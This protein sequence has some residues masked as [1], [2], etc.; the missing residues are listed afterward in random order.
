MLPELPLSVEDTAQIFDVGLHLD[1][2][3][4]NLQGR[5]F[6]QPPSSPL[7]MEGLP[8]WGRDTLRPS[9]SLRCTYHQGGFHL[10]LRPHLLIA[11]APEGGE[12]VIWIADDPRRGQ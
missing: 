8:I 7:K 3:P 4:A 10:R 2:L 5:V 11:G 6:R 1:G 9:T 12:G